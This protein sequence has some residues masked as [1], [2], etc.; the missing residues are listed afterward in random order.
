MILRVDPKNPKQ[1]IVDFH[2]EHKRQRR[3]IDQRRIYDAGM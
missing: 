1:L 3:T 2:Y